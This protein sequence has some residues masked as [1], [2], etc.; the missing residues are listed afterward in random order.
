MTCRSVDFLIWRAQ[1]IAEARRAFWR[2]TV[3]PLVNRMTR[4]IE[5]LAIA[6]VWRCA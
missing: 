4:A 5:W 2:Q 6:G 1:S 3:L